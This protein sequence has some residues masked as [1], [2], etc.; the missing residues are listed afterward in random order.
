MLKE[1]KIHCKTTENYCMY[2]ITY[3]LNSCIKHIKQYNIILGS[4]VFINN[5]CKII[6]C[7]KVK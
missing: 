5:V 7:C 1:L 4:T 2:Y 6:S 3:E